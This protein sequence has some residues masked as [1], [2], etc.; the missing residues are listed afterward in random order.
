M[1]FPER[2]HST[3]SITKFS[4]ENTSSSSCSLLFWLY[5]SHHYLSFQLC[6]TAFCVHSR[7]LILPAAHHPNTTQNCFAA[8]CLLQL[9]FPHFTNLHFKADMLADAHIGWSR[10]MYGGWLHGLEPND[11]AW[12]NCSHI[13]AFD[14][15]NEQTLSQNPELSLLW[16]IRSG[17]L[18]HYAHMLDF[19]SDFLP[20]ETKF[21]DQEQNWKFW[22]VLVWHAHRRPINCL[23]NYS[24]HVT[25]FCQNVLAIFLQCEP[26]GAQQLIAKTAR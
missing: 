13:T 5:A 12:I 1:F 14:T 10:W 19:F 6:N 8:V 9:L 22:I 20:S 25:D 11:S 4:L 17:W 24:C 7:A 21:V 2:S 16:W 15:K 18:K 23:C 26:M 3:R